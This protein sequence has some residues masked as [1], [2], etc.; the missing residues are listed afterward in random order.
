M[1]L[2]KEMYREDT[3]SFIFR[4]RRHA[5]F[6]VETRVFI[7]G[8]TFRNIEGR[9]VEIAKLQEVFSEKVLEQVI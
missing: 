2:G 6:S 3:F 1:K 4:L 5:L 7:Y 8:H 9:V